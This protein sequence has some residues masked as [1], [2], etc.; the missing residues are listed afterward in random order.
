MVFKDR[1]EAG[2]KLALRLTEYKGK[3]VVVYAL[4]RGGIVPAYEIAKFLR[5]PLELIIVQKIGHP[6]N[7]EFAL[8][9]IA[10]DG[11]RILN[12]N[13]RILIDKAWLDNEIRK[14]HEEAKRRRLLY[15][16]K[17]EPVSAKGKIAIVVD[18][19]VATGLTMKLAIVE[20]THQYPKKIVVAVPVCTREFAQ[21]VKNQGHSIVAVQIPREFRGGVGAYY[22]K[23]P[24]VTDEEVTGF[25][26]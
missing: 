6:T 21:E 19:G 17:R 2:K 20:L 3:D 10:P 25:L 23:F 15:V 5:V 9:A 14:K 7:S 11:H 12:E 4:V 13:E 1:K 18:D 16:G 22:E 24:Q 26:R 8:G